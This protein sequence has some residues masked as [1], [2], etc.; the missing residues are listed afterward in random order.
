MGTYLV[1]G[2]AGFI[3]SH[4]SE[5]LLAAGHRVL[6]IDDVST[7][8]LR[9]IAHLNSHPRFEYAVDT[10]LN[11][12]RLAEWVVR[13]D[14]IFHLAAAVGVRLVVEHPVQTIET[15][16][17]GTAVVLELASAHHK[18]VLIASSS[19]VYGKS[20]RVPFREEDDLVLGNTSIG[21]WSYAC[22]KA[23]DEF[24]ALAY[25]RETQLP[26]IVVRL[27]NTAGPRQTGRYGMVLPTFVQQALSARPITVHGDGT[28]R[29]CF[30]DVGD[31]VEALVKLID[32]PGA[33][34]RVFN[35]GSDEEISIG[36]LAERVRTLTGSTSEIVR[37]PY[38]HAWDAQFEDMQRRVPDLTRMRALI[39]FRARTS[40]DEIIRRV[41]EHEQPA[42]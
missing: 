42:R 6:V 18:K 19:E 3:G 4:L 8:S 10:V 30:A 15:N 5:A 25:A 14:G 31:V 2:G 40:L 22:T 26:V 29:R 23:L 1:T 9:N 41:I 27:F 28:Q 33:I 38:E 13:V 35:I 39:G 17:N 7:G 20:T 11:R 21:R 37:I 32:H 34:G 12:S 16:V 24:L 36:A